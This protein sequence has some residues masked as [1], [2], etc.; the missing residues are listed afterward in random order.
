MT[1]LSMWYLPFLTL[2]NWSSAYHTNLD[3]LNISNKK[4]VIIIL[5][6]K[7]REHAATLFKELNTLPLDELIQLKRGTFM[8]KLDNNLLPQSNS[9]WFLLSHSV[10]RKRLNLSKHR[11]P[12]PKIKYTKIHNIYSAT[13]LWNTEIPI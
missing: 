3:C 1:A 11:I 7:G 2:P 4:A 6:K 13:K 5:L 12:N 8:W 10:I 9:G